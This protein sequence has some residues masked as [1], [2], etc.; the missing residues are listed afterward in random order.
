MS[1]PGAWGRVVS[2][3]WKYVRNDFSK[4]NYIAEDSHGNRYY[5][6]TNSRQ[7]VARGFEA[8]PSG[9]RIEPGIEW[10]A[11]LRGTRRFPPSDDEI[12]LNRMKQQAQIAQD[13]HTEKRAPLVSSQG[14][15]AGDHHPQKFPKYED[16][17]ISPGAQDGPTNNKK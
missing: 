17:E 15:G 16:L 1:R 4:K 6:I 11:W 8:P 13:A 2:N 14:I 9:P 5:E 3:L 12:A 10:Q 7:N